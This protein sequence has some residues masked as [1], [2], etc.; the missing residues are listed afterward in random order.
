MRTL[1]VLAALA[2]TAGVA[3]IGAPGAAQAPARTSIRAAGIPR[4]TEAIFSTPPRVERLPNGLTVVSVAWPSPGI[5]A[6][7]TLVRVGSRDEVE[8]GHSGFAHFFEHM[9]FR[10]TEA[11][12]QHDYE[13]ILQGFGADNNAF[14][15]SDYTCYTITAPSSALSTV[16]ELE[17]DRFAHLSYTEDTFRTEA[18]AVRGEY[19]VWSSNPFQPMWETLSEIA[20]TRH[21]YGHTTIGFLR[22][23]DVMPT[24][25]EYARRFFQRFYTPDNTFVIVV[26]DVDHDALMGEVRTR[27][28]AW[29]GRRD[30]PRIPTEPEPT[31]GVRRDLTWDGS[32]PPRVFVGYRIPAFEGEGSAAARQRTLRE[33]AAL[34]IVHGLAFHESSPLYQRLVVEEQQLLELESW[35]ADFNRDPGLFVATATLTPGRPFDPAIDAIQA[36]LT[37]VAA[38]EIEPARIRAVQEHLRYSMAMSLETPSSVAGLLANVLAMSG[39]VEALDE[40]LEHL[41]SVTPQEVAAAAGRYLV[42]ARR[43]VVTLAQTDAQ[44]EGA[45]G[46]AESATGGAQ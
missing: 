21:T 42:P 46:A 23:I 36:E 13:R 26:G 33:T 9:M 34:Q 32:T 6:Y 10:G 3:L 22:D 41:A 14:T 11:H 30:R 31:A 29:R 27:Y 15:T 28:G 19:Q 35:A 12:S 39:R 24:R 20:F 5:V 1:P 18:G 25:Y 43:M 40:Y 45:E 2:L 44:G 16:I 8:A 4:P 7:Y 37:R 38:G 17:A